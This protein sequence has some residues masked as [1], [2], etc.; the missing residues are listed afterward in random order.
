MLDMQTLETKEIG[1]SSSFIHFVY[2]NIFYYQEANDSFKLY[3]L[4]EDQTRLIME[5]PYRFEVY[6]T[7]F[8]LIDKSEKAVKA[9]SLPDLKELK[10]PGLK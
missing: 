10:F 1:E 7:G 3:I 6:P 4:K 9:Y 5:S 8:L 2:P